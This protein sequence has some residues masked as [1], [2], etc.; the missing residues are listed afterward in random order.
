MWIQARDAFS[1]LEVLSTQISRLFF[2]E[3]LI[4][5]SWAIWMTRNNKICKQINA[6]IAGCKN[7]FL[8]E[9]GAMLLRAK[10]SYSPRLQEW[11]SVLHDF[12]DFSCSVV[13]FLSFFLFGRPYRIVDYLLLAGLV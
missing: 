8:I 9:M 10:K 2:M 5:I 1:N 13:S 3:I 6:S 12:W 7:L 4:L 11:I